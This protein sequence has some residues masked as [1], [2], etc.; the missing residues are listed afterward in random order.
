[1]RHELASTAHHLHKASVHAAAGAGS[2][3]SKGYLAA[4]N[5]AA[6]AAGKLGH[7]WQSTVSTLAPLVE[8]A[9]HEA[10][11]ANKAAHRQRGKAK[12]ASRRWAYIAGGVLLGGAAVAA[13]AYLIRRKRAAAPDAVVEVDVYADEPLDRVAPVVNDP[14]R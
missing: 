1:M 2:A 7:G 8:A 10:R 6:P 11:T 5:A 12:G 4:R 13:A 3:A 9:T 14:A